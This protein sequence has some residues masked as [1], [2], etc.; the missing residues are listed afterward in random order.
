MPC[1]HCNIPSNIY[2]ASI[3]SEILRFVIIIWD[4]NTYATFS[5]CLLKE[6]RNKKVNI[7]PLNKIFGKHFTVF[8]DFA[9]TA[10]NSIKLFLLPWLRSSHIRVCLLHRLFLLFVCS[11]FCLFALC[12]YHVIIA[13]Y[14]FV[15]MYFHLFIFLWVGILYYNFTIIQYVYRNQYLCI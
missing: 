15:S 8:N 5:C 14:I 2:Y 7:D 3:G 9:D 11:L 6:F 10:A 4:I 13:S 1:V 12:D